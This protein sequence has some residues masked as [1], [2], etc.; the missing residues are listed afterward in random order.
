ME[1]T[2]QAWHFDGETAIRREVDVRIV[3]RTFALYES[4]RRSDPIGF[5]ELHYVGHQRQSAVYGI[6]G[7]DGW[8]LGLNGDVPSDLAALLPRQKKYGGF[9]DRIGIGPSMIVLAGISAACIA[10]ASYAPQWIAPLIPSSV[11]RQ[12]GAALVG[13]FAGHFCHTPKGD[14]A[15]AKLAR[16]LDKNPNDLKIN[17]AKFDMVNAVALPGGNIVLFDGL[18]RKSKSP[19]AV[20][21][22]L[23]HEMGHV[24]ER[25]VMQSLLRQLGMSVVLSG[26]NGNAG[27]MLNNVLSLGYGRNAEKEAD[28]HSI[29][30]M[31]NASI[32][33]IDTADFFEKMGKEDGSDNKEFR[34]NKVAG[35]MT[36]HPNS[37]ERQS[38]FQK[39]VIKGKPYKPALTSEEWFELKTMCTQDLKAGSDIDRK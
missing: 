15:L 32:S 2:F 12:L 10:I 36:S 37:I 35:Y 24:R 33:P 14:A 25:H 8:R 20:A 16:S 9:I 13:D 5:D 27:G 3:G 30:A 34:G 6:T 7:R 28:A 38:N 4:D 29:K 17:V 11:E 39:S 18:V 21:G 23:A 19:D 1:R 22:V 31:A 26:A